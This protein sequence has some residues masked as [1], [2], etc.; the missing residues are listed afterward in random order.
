MRTQLGDE[1][2]RLHDPRHS[3][4][5]F[6]ILAGASIH[7]VKELFGHKDIATTQRNT[8]LGESPIRE[9]SDGIGDVIAG[10]F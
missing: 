8:H 3:F 7:V 2:L 5:S 10:V 9:A 1:K 4:A 6:A